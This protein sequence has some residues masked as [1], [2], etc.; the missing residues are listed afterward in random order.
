[1]Y[2][3]DLKDGA[4]RRNWVNGYEKWRFACGF[5]QKET[6]RPIGDLRV[7]LIYL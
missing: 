7:V 4:L 3:P 1:M 6:R 2:I 5:S